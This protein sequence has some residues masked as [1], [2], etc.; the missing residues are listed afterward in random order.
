MM[1][2][3]RQRV[4]DNMTDMASHNITFLV[5]IITVSSYYQLSESY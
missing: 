1:D 4:T 3:V 2:D 5:N